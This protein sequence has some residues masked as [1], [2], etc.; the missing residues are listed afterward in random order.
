[1]VIH[2]CSKDFVDDIYHES[3]K[4]VAR[5]FA[6]KSRFFQDTKS[7]KLLSSPKGMSRT[8]GKNV[9]LGTRFNNMSLYPIIPTSYCT[10]L[11]AEFKYC[12]F[13][14]NSKKIKAY[15]FACW[16]INLVPS[17]S[18]LSRSQTKKPGAI[19]IPWQQ[20]AITVI[21]FH[22]AKRI[23]AHQIWSMVAHNFGQYGSIQ[24]TI[25]TG[26]NHIVGHLG[27]RLATTRMDLKRATFARY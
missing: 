13:T 15:Q 27:L 23:V 17:P 22:P 11:L 5:F 20:H 9:L 10:F 7:N 24:G 25:T 19:Q 4:E 6:C 12:I 3:T 21:S 18:F 8:Q 26:Y 16:A 1:M 14:E 2:L